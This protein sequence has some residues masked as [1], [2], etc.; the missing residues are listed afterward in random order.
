MRT[1]DS[2]AGVELSTSVVLDRVG[3]VTGP[4]QVPL[5][6]VESTWLAPGRLKHAP[7]ASVEAYMLSHAPAHVQIEPAAHTER[8]VL[9]Q[10]ATRAKALKAR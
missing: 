4:G 6:Y 5:C 10:L 2:E 9:E 8:A 3:Q 7:G 1:L